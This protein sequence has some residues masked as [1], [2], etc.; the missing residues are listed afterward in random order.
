MYICTFLVSV[1]YICIQAESLQKKMDALQ[2]LKHDRIVQY[3][4]TER[5]ESSVFIFME[6]I[7][8]VSC[9]ESNICDSICKNPEQSLKPIFSV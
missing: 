5:R 4:G 9:F 8:G 3:F 6:Y 1:F 2:K 7:A